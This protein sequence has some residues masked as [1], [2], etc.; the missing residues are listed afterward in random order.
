MGKLTV[1][2]E[3]LRKDQALQVATLMRMGITK[4]DACKRVGISEPMFR[5]WIIE[6]D[7]ALELV[8]NALLD[9]RKGE[10]VH[11]LLTRESLVENL[12]ASALSPMTMVGEKLAVT[13]W[14]INYSN[15][16]AQDL[17]LKDTG[18]ADFLTGAK[19]RHVESRFGGEQDEIEITI[20]TKRGEHDIIDITPTP[21]NGQEE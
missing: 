2:T 6:A 13:Q 16:V 19:L 17:H 4:D 21:T 5:R 18:D 7:N 12:I 15:A 8:D 9:I 1:A 10:L 3:R 14:V 20:R 11:M